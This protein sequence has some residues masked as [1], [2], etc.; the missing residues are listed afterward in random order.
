MIIAQHHIVI[1]SD[2]YYSYQLEDLNVFTT[3]DNKLK[4]LDHKI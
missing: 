3:A 4:A 1:D 2:C